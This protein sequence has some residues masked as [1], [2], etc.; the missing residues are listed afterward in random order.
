MSGICGIVNLD[1]APVEL[2][3]LEKMTEA[4]IYRGPDGI[5]TWTCDNVGLAHLAHHT[6]P[7]ALQVTGHSRQSRPAAV[8]TRMA[9]VWRR[10]GHGEALDIHAPF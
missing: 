3:L 7:E 5:N 6:T 4:S 9:G 1:G 10:N 8:Q 2:E